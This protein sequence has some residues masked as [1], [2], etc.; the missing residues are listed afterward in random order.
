MVD[1]RILAPD[2]PD[3][4][5][6]WRDARLAALRDAP[7]AFKV[8]LSDWPTGGEQ[9]WRTRFARRDAVHLVAV[10]ADGWPV[11]LAGGLPSP[12]RD[13]AGEVRSLWVGPEA[14]GR[15][16]GDRLLAA[17]EAWA[18]RTGRTS[19]RLAVLMGNTPAEALYR[20]NGFVGVD[21]ARD[22]RAAEERVMVKQL[23]P[24]AR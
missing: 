3:D 16:T 12:G 1:L 20:R 7:H 4:W 9:E 24:V 8:R 19:L 11:G 15:R 14:R 6:L 23:A 5:P 22:E 2:D 10:A 21:E 18:R 17:V 13:G